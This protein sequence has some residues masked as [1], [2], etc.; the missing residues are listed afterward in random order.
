MKHFRLFLALS[1]L[2]IALLG[3]E[4]E[5]NGNA[6]ATGEDNSIYYQE[7]SVDTTDYSNDTSFYDVDND[8]LFD[9]EVSHVIVMKNSQAQYRGQFKWI[10]ELMEFCYMKYA[11]SISMIEVGDQI[12]GNQNIF[13]WEPNINYSGSTVV[14]NENHYWAHGLFTEYFGFK[15]ISDQGVL[16]GWFRFKH[17][18]L[19]EMA[20][21]TNFNK[22]IFVGQ[23]R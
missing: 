15:Y 3:C 8:G 7:F 6:N 1:T 11:P 12:N 16:Y 20:V 9:I 13:K 4:K 23:R 18:E 21:N 19:A 17:F 22:P 2:L 10:N 14:M 5:E